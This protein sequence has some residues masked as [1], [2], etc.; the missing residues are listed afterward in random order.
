MPIFNRWTILPCVSAQ[1][2]GF[3]IW[4]TKNKG[5]MFPL[6]PCTAEI[7]WNFAL[8]CATRQL[9]WPSQYCHTTMLSSC[10]LAPEQV[11]PKSQSIA[12]QK[13]NAS[14]PIYAAVILPKLMV[15]VSVLSFAVYFPTH[16]LQIETQGREISLFDWFCF[17]FGGLFF[18]SGWELVDYYV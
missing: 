17:I 7:W 18:S 8:L 10:S 16:W 15:L 1:T 2:C 6:A 3:C 4:E 5:Q 11:S 12:F 13:E 14:L 9:H